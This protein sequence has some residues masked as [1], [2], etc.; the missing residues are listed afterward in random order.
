MIP[1]AGKGIIIDFEKAERLA[2]KGLE[3]GIDILGCWF[4]FCQALRRKLASM[5][6]LYELVRKNDKA[7][8][9]FRQFQCLALLPAEM[10]ESS[11]IELSKEALK[12]SKLFAP[13]IDYFYKEWIKIVKP[14][15][16]S[17]FMRGIRT[18][19]S[20][21]A[22]NGQ[23]NKRF[24]THGNLFHFCESMQKEELMIC[25]RLE[26]DIGGTIQKDNQST[27]YKRREKLIRKY[28]LMVKNG[29]MDPMLFLRTMANYKSKI[30]G[31]MN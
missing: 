25:Q 2:L 28:S 31:L 9:I 15:H 22:F 26:N 19:A 29:E 21:E 5:S 17:V 6:D 13:L 24:K 8:G 10:I 1:I 3:S 16:F 18:T 7:K 20:A 4:H 30:L 11:F 12:C 23:I 14:I 27:F